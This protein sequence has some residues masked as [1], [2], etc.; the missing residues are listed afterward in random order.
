M[1]VADPL[2]PTQALHRAQAALE[3]VAR[4]SRGHTADPGEESRRLQDAFEK[5]MDA[6]MLA[7][8]RA[9][10]TEP[11][12]IPPAQLQPWLNEDAQRWSRIAQESGI[13]PD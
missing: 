4:L 8:L 2:T 6:A 9:N 13:R 12:V 1:T 10:F 3:M 11:L 7:R 5:S